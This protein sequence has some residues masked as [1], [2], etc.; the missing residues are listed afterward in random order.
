M[1]H[2]GHRL[3]V[4][5]DNSARPAGRF[6]QILDNVGGSALV[7]NRELIGAS[8]PFTRALSGRPLSD[9]MIRSLGWAGTNR[10]V[11]QTTQVS[12]L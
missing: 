3:V 9:H 4:G 11:V 1:L 10:T 6:D 2:P 8:C 7:E 12:T 5:T